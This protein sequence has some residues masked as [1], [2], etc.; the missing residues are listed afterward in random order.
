MMRCMIVAP[1][2]IFP[3]ASMSTVHM[4]IMCGTVKSKE[5]QVG[6]LPFQVRVNVL[7]VG[8]NTFQLASKIQDRDEFS[9]EKKRN[10]GYCME[11]KFLCR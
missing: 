10:M 7:K 2:I 9:V 5:S 8:G 4:D 6:L 1:A 3:S 11:I